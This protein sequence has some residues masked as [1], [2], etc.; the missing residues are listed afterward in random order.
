MATKKSVKIAAFYVIAAGVLWGI[1]SIFVRRLTQGGMTAMQITAARVT[2]GTVVLL[3]VILIKD[4][5]LL[6]IKLK[7]LWLFLGTGLFSVVLFNVCYFYTMQ[8]GEISV[9]VVLLYTSPIFVM[10]MGAVFFKEKITLRKLVALAATVLG[11]VFVSGILGGV[12]MELI[13]LLT[14]I[15]S[16]FFYASYSIF[17]RYAVEKYHPLTVTFYTFLVAMV[18]S[19][20]LCMPGKLIRIVADDKMQILWILGIGVVCTVLPYIFY[21]EGLERMEAGKAAIMV[22]VE[23]L[24]GTLLGIIAY[25]ESANALKIA[26]IV[27]IFAA[28]VFL[29]VK[30]RKKVE[31]NEGEK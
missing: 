22:T 24:V 23:P 5:K 14:G 6:K 2:V 1:I 20:P 16:G 15:G 8:H 21:T 17:G 28:V 7:D 9:A 26:G 12:K 27:L 30:E 11:C 29:N 19:V 13:T 31:S 3:A 10:L 4:T 25:K 18:T